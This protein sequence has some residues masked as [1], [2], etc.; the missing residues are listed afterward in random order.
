MLDETVPV[1]LHS[2]F[3]TATNSFLA[4]GIMIALCLG[5]LL[6]DEVLLDKDGKDIGLNTAGLKADNNWRVIYGF[7]YICQFLT[8]LM[9][10][11]CYREDSITFSIGA[12]K[13]EEALKLIQ[14]VY[15]SDE[16]PDEILADLKGKSSKGASNVTLTQACCDK[17]YRRSTWVAF[18]LCF[19]QQQTG[20]DGIMIYSNTIF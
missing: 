9:F 11:T 3:G 10:L 4:G 5:V 16:D 20:L 15:K 19:F 8:V 1:N 6:P 2:I 7:P 14:K 18:A 12:G 17:K 13:D